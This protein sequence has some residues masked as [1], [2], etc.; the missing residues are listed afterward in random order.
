MPTRTPTSYAYPSCHTTGLSPATNGAKAG[1]LSQWAFFP[2]SQRGRGYL[3]PACTLE[4]AQEHLRYGRGLG[5]TVPRWDLPGR[6]QRAP[7]RERSG[8]RRCLFGRD[9]CALVT[10][11]AAPGLEGRARAHELQASSAAIYGLCEN[12]WCKRPAKRRWAALLIACISVGIWCEPLGLGYAMWS[13]H[14]GASH[15]DYSRNGAA[16]PAA[17]VTLSRHAPRHA[18]MEC[19]PASPIYKGFLAVLPSTIESLY[20]QVHRSQGAVSMPHGLCNRVV[21]TRADHQAAI[22]CQATPQ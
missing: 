19:P 5:A 21:D 3:E 9:F 20:V 16:V 22:A 2:A 15:L 6:D 13:T 4:S 8:W 7:A 17:R 12:C 1:L 14:N 18:K 10:G 11:K